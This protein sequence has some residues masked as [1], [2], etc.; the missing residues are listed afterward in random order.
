MWSGP[1]NISTALMYSFAQRKDTKVV[2]EP[3]Y[4]YYLKFSNADHPGKDDI[5]AGM[6]SDSSVVIRE[7]A[8]GEYETEIVFFKQMAH[9]LAG[10]DLNFL[11]DFVNILLIR[12]PAQIINSFA[13]VIPEFTISDIGIKKQFEIYEYLCSLNKK[14]VI[15]DSGEI[16]KNP[17]AVLNKLCTALDIPFDSAMLKWNSGP[18]KEDGIWAKY[19]YENV[20]KSTGFEKQPSDNSVLDKRF[21]GLYEE[22]IPYYEKLFS[23]SIKL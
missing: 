9:H 19:W 15:I 16:T 10:L 5:I 23:E 1:R 20:H 3:L 14:P 17:E 6:E 18:K 8:A 12:N 21:I 7:L 2:D 11:K 4:A 22:C 13:K